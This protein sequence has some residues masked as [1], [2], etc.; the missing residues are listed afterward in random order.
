VIEQLRGGYSDRLLCEALDIHR[1]SLYHEPRA[2]RDRPLREALIAL[3]GQWPTYG[4][5]RLTAMLRR[6][7]HTANA[8]RVRRLMGELGLSG[9]PPPRRPRTTNS[10]HSFP[11]F[12][13]LVESLEVTRPDQVWVSEIVHSQ[14]TK[15]AGLAGRPDRERIADLD[16]VP[17]HHD[18]VD[19]QLDQLP[20]PLE[21]RRV[22]TRPHPVGERSGGVHQPAQLG[23]PARLA[24]EQLLLLGQ[25][26]VAAFQLPSPAPVL[27]QHED[28][29]QV[30]LREP[31]DLLDQA[32]PAAPQVL[33]AGL[34]F[35][36]QPASAGRPAQRPR[37]PFRVP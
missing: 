11:R 10:V 30:R 33:A 9:E 24:R 23:R 37:H 8:K 7:G 15:P 17:G 1:S 26:A 35:L 13:N 5:R 28:P 27:A 20:L 22:E 32:R 14:M 36:R 31:F 19:E 16:V 2:D 29:A 3:A 4:Y 18:P 34:Q 12:P 6:E 21:R 25:R